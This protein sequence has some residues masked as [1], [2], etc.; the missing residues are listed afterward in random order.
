MSS[1]ISV[2]DEVITPYGKATVL[3]ISNSAVEVEHIQNLYSTDEKRKYSN[4]E[5]RAAYHLDQL[6]KLDE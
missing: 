4:D 1:E 2:G 5:F 6:E 3:T